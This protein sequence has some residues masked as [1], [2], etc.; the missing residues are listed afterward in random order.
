MILS[1]VHALNYPPHSFG[2]WTAKAP[3]SRRAWWKVAVGLVLGPCLL[4]ARDQAQWGETLTRNMLSVATNL[5][6]NFDPDLRRQIKWSVELGSAC[7]STPVIARGRVFIGTN[8]GNPRNPAHRGDRGVLMCF[9]ES[10]GR[11]A[12][13]LV[14]P[15]Q[16]RDPYLDCPSVGITSTASVDGDRVYVVSNRGEVLAL[17]LEGQA[18]G[19]DGPFLEESRHMTP[20][21]EPPLKAGATDADI[22][23]CFDMRR[24]LGAYT[25]DSANLSVL[26]HGPFLYVST[27]NG[28]NYTH[29]HRPSPDTPG[30]IVLDKLTGKLIARDDTGIGKRVFHSTFSSPSLA[31]INGRAM[32]F[33]GGADGV[34]YAFEALNA[35]QRELYLSLRTPQTLREAWR[36]DCDPTAPKENISQYQGNPSISPSSIIGMPVVDCRRIYIATRAHLYAF[37]LK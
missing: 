20:E 8:N 13:Q 33:Y 10:D 27:P 7:Y 37:A 16:S 19:N 18:D 6:V 14:V 35:A 5:P 4:V 30:L 3:P 26:V 29:R 9:H 28:V 34:C 1:H 17:D 31:E 15:K 11:F 22:I 21:G 2:F 32:V 25:H 24:E 12:W 36:F 23:W